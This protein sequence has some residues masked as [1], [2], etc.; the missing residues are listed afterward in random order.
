ML[1]SPT[2]CKMSGNMWL[3]SPAIL[4][5]FLKPL[6]GPFGMNFSQTP[7][8]IGTS[9]NLHAKVLANQEK[10][11]KANIWKFALRKDFTP[12]VYS[13]DRIA[14]REAKDLLRRSSWQPC[15]LLDGGGHTAEWLGM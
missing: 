2:V 7:A 4:P 9:Y 8:A 11:K 14:G 5:P 1:A 10:E 15:W 12:L 6:N 3:G 13:V